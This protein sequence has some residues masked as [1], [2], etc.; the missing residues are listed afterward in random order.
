[1]KRLAAE[2]RGTGPDGDGAHDKVARDGAAKVTQPEVPDIGV[3]QGIVKR[4]AD[5]EVAIPRS[6]LASE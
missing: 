4:I 1:M 3:S 5:V 6:K 2:K